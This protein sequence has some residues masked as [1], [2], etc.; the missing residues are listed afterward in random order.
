MNVEALAARAATLGAD[1]RLRI[2][3]ALVGFVAVTIATA[4]IAHPRMFTGFANYDDEGYML[5]AL[6]GFV[7]H[8]ELYDRVFTQYG[9]FYYEFWGGIF[10]LFGLSVNHD[11]GRTVTEVVWVLS[12][13]LLGVSL[14]RMTG[15][16]VIGLATQ[17]LGFAPLFVLTNE[18]MHPVGII[19]LLLS[20][21][22]LISTFVR[23]RQSPYAMAILG[24]AVAALLLV[25]VNVGAFAVISVVLACVVSYPVLWRRRWLRYAIEALFVLVPIL[26]MYGKFDLGWARHYAFHVA[27]SALAVVFVLHA[28]ETGRRVGSDLRW[29]V[30]GFLVLAIVSCVAI[31]GA[32]TSIHGLIDGVIK[33]PLRQADAFSI[34]MGLSKRIYAFDFIALGAAVTYWFAARYRS[35]APGPTWRAIWAIFAI[36]VGFTM[37]YAV[38]GQSLPFNA[39][40][41]EGFPLS[42]LPF[43]WVALIPTAP[44]ERTPSF[45][46]LLLPLLAVLQSLHGY[47]VAGSQIQLSALL[48]VPVG[49][50]CVGNGVRGIAAVTEMSADRIALVGLATVAT[51]VLGWFTVNVYLK[52]Q[53]SLA[54]GNYNAGFSLGLPGSSKIHL[55]SEEEVVIYRSVVHGIDQNCAATLMEP[56]MDSFYLWSE[57]EPP[58]YTATGWETLFDVEHQEKVIEDTRADRQLCLLRNNG[59]QAGWGEKE[60]ILTRYLEQG[61]E[62]IGKWGEYELLRREGPYKGSL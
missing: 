29:L 24:A 54:R 30:G 45:A 6:K 57:Q 21:I 27:I 46:R 9:P 42:M 40:T 31:L 13:L 51:V 10:Q 50:L 61:F 8:G 11:N 53:I 41:L 15:S 34:P 14:W 35:A 39:N 44:G 47:P 38:P 17:I 26:L 28:R 52:E 19:A 49:A 59:L 4:L 48:L 60:G 56:G 62:P 33:Q 7:N 43:C 1:R 55:G 5:T 23:E 58:S 3:V 2:V 12:G 22:V 37:I 16:I 20:T 36:V 18:P 25:K 32:G